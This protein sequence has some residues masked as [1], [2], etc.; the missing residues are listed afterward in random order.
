MQHNITPH[1]RNNMSQNTVHVN[2]H[3]IAFN[4]IHTQ[5]ISYTNVQQYRRDYLEESHSTVPPSSHNQ[6]DYQT[7]SQ[8]YDYKGER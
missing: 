6:T 4:M 8:S 2:E 3:N 1:M 5:C 7:K